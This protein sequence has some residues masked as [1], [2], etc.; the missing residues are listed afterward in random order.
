M[1]RTIFTFLVLIITSLVLVDDS[2][3][4]TCGRIADVVFVIDSSRSI[5]PPY[6]RQQLEFVQQVVKEFDVGHS[7]TRIGALTFSDKTISEFHLQKYDNKQDI[8]D[9]ISAISFAKGSATNTFDALRVLRT[10][11]FNEKNGDR[12][13]VPNIAIVLTDGESS[14]KASTVHEAD[15]TRKAGTAIF[16][17]G[18]GN[19]VNKVELEEIASLPKSDY[20]HV[21]ESFK[22]LKSDE[23]TK[24]LSH[25]A[26]TAPLTTPT[27]TKRTTTTTTTPKTTTT[28]IT[29]TTTTEAV[30]IS[31]K[32][33]QEEAER[34]CQ[35]KPADIMFVL[36]VSSSI[37]F[38]DFKTQMN[39]VKDVVDIFD[40]NSGKAQ[41]GII[42]F[43]DYAEVEFRLGQH[44]TKKTLMEAIDMVEY[45]GGSTNTSHALQLLRGLF[46]PGSGSRQG[47]AHIAIVVTDG[48]SQDPQATQNMAMLAHDEGIYVF[49]IGVGNNS[50]IQELQSIASE[51]SG[52]YMYMVNGYK[53]LRSIQS[54]LAYKACEV[55]ADVFA[56]TT[57]TDTEVVFAV[58]EFGGKDKKNV[59]LFIQKV[60]GGFDLDSGHVRVGVMH[61]C[62]ANNIELGQYTTKNSFV[63]AI[64]ASMTGN[65][66]V[67]F[68]KEIRQ[69]GLYDTRSG[70]RK[71][72]V[73]IVSDTFTDWEEAAMEINRLKF[74]TEVNVIGVGERVSRDQLQQLASSQSNI[75]MVEDTAKMQDIAL[76]IHKLLCSS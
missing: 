34:A 23:F 12:P 33:Q 16:A 28:T 10:E 4:E 60:G 24:L 47:V 21:L 26:C 50:D 69:K 75:F 31:T 41:V 72:L 18:I 27:T 71:K 15:L 9:A 42:T 56:C 37:W 17:I 55:Q 25:K 57:K 8:L 63:E 54:I 48:Q 74:K 44:K 61:K 6:F 53:A 70:A 19:M 46:K 5:W 62:N 67:P 11:F 36:D 64:E 73:L 1:Y 52:Q 68:L 32:M 45:R 65:K 39:F 58:D 38:K 22:D 59:M 14:N 2:R 29:T 40:V 30:A 66:V 7:K 3:A 51:P 35:G 76:K 20:M 49:A 13:D 43:S